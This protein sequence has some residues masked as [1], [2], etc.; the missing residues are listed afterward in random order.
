MSNLI[1]FTVMIVNWI[2]IRST[3][4]HLLPIKIYTTVLHR[5]FTF[6]PSKRIMTA[7][8]TYVQQYIG[9]HKYVGIFFFLL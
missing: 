2:R 3:R 7:Y 8:K 6:P 9:D 5:R 4:I 1:R